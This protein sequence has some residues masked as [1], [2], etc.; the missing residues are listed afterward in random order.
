MTDRLKTGAAW[1]S[2][3]MRAHAASSVTYTRGPEAIPDLAATKGR[4]QFELADASG[5]LTRVDSV[6]FIVTAADLILSGVVTLPQRGDTITDAAGVVHAVYP[7]N[8]QDCW[9]WSDTAGYTSLRIH[10]KVTEDE[11]HPE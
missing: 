4:T 1:L 3:Q 10:T 8:G 11:A 2:Q 9:R 5:V 6:D 7:F